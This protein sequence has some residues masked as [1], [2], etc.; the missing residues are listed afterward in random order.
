MKRENFVQL[1]F[2]FRRII[3][4]KEP[5]SWVAQYTFVRR[6]LSGTENDPPSHQYQFNAIFRMKM[7]RTSM[8]FEKQKSE[9]MR[10]DP[11]TATRSAMF[12][13]EGKDKGVWKQ[14]FILRVFFQLVSNT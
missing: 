1:P 2:Y 14:A 4:A 5:G 9:S 11:L 13:A 12:C 3:S 10:T 6:E 8:R 7:K